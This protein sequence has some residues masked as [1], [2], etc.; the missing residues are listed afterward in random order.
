M[1]FQFALDLPPEKVS[2]A[3]A[4]K[5]N[6]FSWDWHDTWQDSHAKAFTVAKVVRA[7]ILQDIRGEVQKAIDE[8]L[9]FADFQKNLEPMLKAKGWWG[10]QTLM[11]ADGFAQEVQLGS[12]W[13]LKSIY[14]N[15]LQ[16]QYMAGR[17]K[18][19]KEVAKFLPFWQ[20]LA[21]LDEQT[22]KSHAALNGKV[23]RHDD[24]FWDKFYPPNG[25]MCRCHVRNL[26]QK[27]LERKKLGIEYSETRIVE[28]EVEIGGKKRKI[29]SYKAGKGQMVTPDHGWG[30]NPGKATYTPDLTKYDDNIKVQ[31][32]KDLNEIN[33]FKPAKNLKEAESFAKRHLADNVNFK[34]SNIEVVNEA[35]EAYYQHM[36]DFPKFGR[37]DFWG[38]TQERYRYGVDIYSEALQKRYE[39]IF[40]KNS[41]QATKEY[42]IKKS[43]SAFSNWRTG[44]NVWA[45]STEGILGSTNKEFAL[46]EGKGN[47]I[48]LNQTWASKP[49]RFKESLVKN[50]ELEFHPLGCNTIKSIVDHELGHQLDDLL[51]LKKNEKILKIRSDIINSDTTIQEAVSAYAGNNINEFIAE[52][53]AEYRN[54]K[55][56]RPTAKAVAE[57]IIE[58]YEKYDNL[59]TGG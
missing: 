1:G 4:D 14:R 16:T 12:P 42:A 10:K 44:Q 51:K 47:G 18:E 58:E 59:N 52:C 13:R 35:N 57:I 50:C 23:F 5:G 31:V 36:Q 54:N 39:K 2:K 38:T 24:S 37:R 29:H 33:K 27:Q 43:R 11:D 48:A 41:I 20:Y 3:F 25:W 15:N 7:D 8:G 56:C 19:M 9:P 30:Y 28:S 49:D 34:G 26:S 17:Y 22:R 21:V 6:V 40:G 55:Q 45:N 46:L 32:K 53:W